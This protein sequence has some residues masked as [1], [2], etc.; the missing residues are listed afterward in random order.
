[1]PPGQGR[2]APAEINAG[3]DE[4]LERSPLG[5][6]QQG[7]G[8]ARIKV[9]D[10]WQVEH[11]FVQ[12]ERLDEGGAQL[13]WKNTRFGRVGYVSKGPVLRSEDSQAVDTIL[14]ALTARA[15]ELGLRA[16]IVQ[17]PDDS[18]MA[19]EDFCR[20]GFNAE[21]MKYV[22]RATATI[23][24]GSGREKYLARMG[25]QARR[26]ARVAQ[27]RGVT[28]RRGTRADLRQFFELM[29]ETC[30]RQQTPPNPSRPEL[31]EALWDALRPRMWLGMASAGGETLAG[32]VM[33]GHGR[34]LTFWKKGW[35]A[36]GLH[37]HAN[38]LLMLECLDWACAGGYAEV[39]FLALDLRIAETLLS[40]GTLTDEQ[41]RSRDKFNLRLGAQPRLLPPAR[42]LVVNPVLRALYRFACRSR[43]IENALM[44]RLGPG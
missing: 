31:L 40:G 9:L 44:R 15:G 2:L 19:A 4:F 33:I 12:P 16:L 29:A 41:Q 30:R 5:Q 10:G 26:E 1:M 37:L 22:T 28:V 17:P 35:N 24:V 14:G 13:L 6:F 25:R 39:D 18:R 27:D 34:R 32:M 42:L 8:W 11:L 23:D 7:S 3:W 36:R 38:T 21:P 43:K 20:H